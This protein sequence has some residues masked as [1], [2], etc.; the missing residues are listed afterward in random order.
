MSTGFKMRLTKIIVIVAINVSIKYPAA[1]RHPIAELHQTV[2][3][4]VS[5]CTLNPSLKIIPAHK[6]PIPVTTCPL[7]RVMLRQLLFLS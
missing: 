2:T 5:P 6:K 1:A 7:T 3:D 4:V